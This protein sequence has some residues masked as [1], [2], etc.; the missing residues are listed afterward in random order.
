MSLI[1]NKAITEKQKDGLFRQNLIEFI[2]KQDNS[3]KNIDFSGY[4]L[5]Q[6]IFLKVDVE[7]RKK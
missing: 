1:K 3:Y 6:L 2:K 7:I 5:T 4:K